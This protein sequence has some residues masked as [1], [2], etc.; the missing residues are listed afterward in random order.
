[1]SSLVL[2]ILIGAI[3]S[4]PY[5]PFKVVNQNIKMGVPD[6][7]DFGLFQD[8]DGTAYIIYTAHIV[9]YRIFF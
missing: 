7:G 5:G 8:D 1:M 9:N 6:T 2:I 3:S 4:T